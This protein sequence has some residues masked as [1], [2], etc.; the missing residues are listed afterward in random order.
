M[1]VNGSKIELSERFVGETMVGIEGGEIYVAA[2][3]Q[4]YMMCDGK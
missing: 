3:S 2:L 1:S 4:K